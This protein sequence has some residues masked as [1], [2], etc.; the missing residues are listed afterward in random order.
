MRKIDIAY[1]AGIL[2]GEGT[3]H[4]NATKTNKIDGYIKPYKYNLHVKVRTC[5]KILAPLFKEF[6]KIGSLHEC[7][8][9]KVNHNIS[10]EYHTASNNAIKVIKILL[11]YLKVKTKQAKL[12]IKFQNIKGNLTY[13]G[14]QLSKRCYD[15]QSRCYF[16]MKKLNKRGK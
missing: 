13:T 7:K 2:D 10:Y 9:Y 15:F 14:K 1:L 5:D 12:A 11:P 3:I 16:N 8:A 6:F 4:I